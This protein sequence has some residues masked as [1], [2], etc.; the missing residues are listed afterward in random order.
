MNSSLRGLKIDRERA[1]R[2]AALVGLAAIGISTLP[3]LLDTPDPPPI[4]ADVG[5]RPAE[6]ARYSG[7]P[8]PT[9][10]TAAKRQQEAKRAV[11]EERKRPNHR[12]RR[13]GLPRA[14]ERQVAAP[15]ASQTPDP[16]LTAT[17]SSPH[18]ETQPAPVAPTP[19]PAPAAPPPA[20]PVPPPV[21]SQPGD[22]SEEFA[23][24]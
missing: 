22:G 13:K 1:A 21:P 3:S 11:K 9:G 17:A 19:P 2:L 4:P 20:L 18:S 23:P 12:R 16:P 10:N 24:R 5:F 6:M 7:S 8:Q 15:A 14:G